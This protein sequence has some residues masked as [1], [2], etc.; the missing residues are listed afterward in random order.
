MKIKKYFLYNNEPI[1]LIKDFEY[2]SIKKF[3][4]LKS[5]SL[6]EIFIAD[7]LDNIPI[8]QKDELIKDI[9]DKLKIGGI[10][11]IQ[12]L[13]R[14]AS[15]AAILNKQVD[16]NFINTLLFSNGRKTISSMSEIIELL[17]KHKFA[18]DQSKFINGIQYFIKAQV[19]NNE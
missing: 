11:Y 8:S 3:I 9:K 4:K 6:D 17:K 12:S 7:L 5:Q 1:N 13:D 2:C 15:S 14:Y 18:V 10:L 16:N 19:I